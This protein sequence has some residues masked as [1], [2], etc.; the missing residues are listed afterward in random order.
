MYLIHYPRQCCRGPPHYLKAA[1][2]YVHARS[3]SHFRS[4]RQIITISPLFSEV[5][6]MTRILRAC[7]AGGLLSICTMSALGYAAVRVMYHDARPL[8]VLSNAEMRATFGDGCTSCAQLIPCL[9]GLAVGDGTY[10]LPLHGHD[11]R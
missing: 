4:L 6:E 11:D 7:V 2:I 8:V 1:R 3:S 10:L 5:N 9:N